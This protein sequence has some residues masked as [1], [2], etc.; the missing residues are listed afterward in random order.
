[1]AKGPG[2]YSDIGKKARGNSHTKCLSLYILHVNNM[3]AHYYYYNFVWIVMNADL[4]YRDFQN[5]HMFALTTS[6]QNGMVSII[7]I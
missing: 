1:M 6:T 3:H 2:L 4:L 5:D 7:Y